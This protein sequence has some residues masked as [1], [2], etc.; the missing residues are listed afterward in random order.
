M[1][2]EWHVRPKQLTNVRSA[3]AD[4]K[5]ILPPPRE[6][7]LESAMEFIDD[8]ECIEVTPTAISTWCGAVPRRPSG[9]SWGT[10][11]PGR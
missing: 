9:S 11:S 10:R 5:Q 4:E 8:D 6:L 1:R 3:G 7:T 2:P